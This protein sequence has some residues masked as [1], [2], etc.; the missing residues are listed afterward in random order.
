MLQSNNNANLS[1]NLYILKPI[2]KKAGEKIRPYFE[3]SK[4]ENGKWVV[5]DDQSINKV[6]G[7]LFKIEAYEEE[8]NGDKYYRTRI[9]LKDNDETYI[10]P[11]RMNIA[12]RSLFNSLFS[13][14]TFEDVSIRFYQTKSG[15]EAFYVSQNEEK[16]KWKYETDELPAATEVTFKG[17]VIRDFTDVDKFFVEKINE[18]NDRLSGK[19][20]SGPVPASAATPQST[21]AKKKAKSK[22]EPEEEGVPEEVSF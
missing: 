5:Q 14:E 12:S 16:V 13:L 18:L 3:I 17:K 4:S 20:T 10:V 1:S 15:Y 9:Y 11:C 7:T 2:S 6:T 21:P 19:N 22:P 8:Y